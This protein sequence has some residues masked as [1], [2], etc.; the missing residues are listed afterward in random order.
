M[1]LH[2]RHPFPFTL[3]QPGAKTF[4]V[5]YLLESIARASM[6]TVLPVTAFAVFGDKETVSLVYTLVSLAALCISFTIPVL[7][8]RL[9]RRWTYTLGAALLGLCGTLIWLGIDWTLPL[10]IL[11]R[12]SGAAMLNVTLSLYIMD[13]INRK[14]LVRSEPMRLGA[15]TL[16]WTTVPFLGVWLLQTY[17]AWAPSLLCILAT[18]ALLSAFWVLRLKEGTP[19]RPGPAQPRTPLRAIR[20]FAEQPRLRL[21][22]SIAFARSCFWQTFFI[23]IPILML[24]GGRDATAA[25]IAIAAGNLMLATN[26]FMGPVVTRLSL[27]RTIGGALLAGSAFVCAAAAL[28]AGNAV[29]ASIAMVGGA[30]FVSMLDGLGPIPFLRA[31]HAFER[32]AM[33]TVYRTYIDASELLPPMVYFFLFM[34]FGFPGAFA[35]LALLLAGIGVLTLRHLPRGL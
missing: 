15:S 33:T 26:L 17:G 28:S 12:T 9:S 35:A 19:I 22:W 3:A 25:G 29:L 2:V 4:S 18:L 11:V 24:E 6:V 7:V 21:A 34:I 23:Y 8:R 13:N 30:F 14:A 16:S 10:A 27:R 5:L 20:R 1:A 32:P 31:V